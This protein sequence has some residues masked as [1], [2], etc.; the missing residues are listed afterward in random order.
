[1]RLRALGAALLVGAVSLSVTNAQDR[2]ADLPKK[3]AAALDKGVAWLKKAQVADGSF[4]DNFT[5]FT[6]AGHMKMGTTALAALALLKSGIK[7]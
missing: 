5:P 1:M 3:R 7:P 6:G 4:D 2:D